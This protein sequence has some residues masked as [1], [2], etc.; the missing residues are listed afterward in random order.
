MQ[1]TFQDYAGQFDLCSGTLKTFDIAMDTMPDKRMRT[2]RVFL[3]DTYDG[4]R[5]FPVMYMH[6]GQNLFAGYDHRLMWYIEREMPKLPLEAQ[7]IVVGIDTA[8]TRREEL[9]PTWPLTPEWLERDPESRALGQNYIS[10]ICD[11]VKPII[12][13]NF[14]TKPEKEFTAIGGASMGGVISFYGHITRPEIF[15]RSLCFS[16]ALICHPADFYTSYFETYDFSQIRDDRIYFYNG[17]T[18]IEP[19]FLQPMLDMWKL[20]TEKGMDY[21]HVCAIVDTREPH[22]ETAWQKWYGDALK[23]LFCKDNSVIENSINKQR[24]ELYDRRNAALK[25]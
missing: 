15:G 7:C 4:E 1:V 19:R 23:Y 10:F 16:P 8:K 12:D 3:P 2:V 14:L 5:R 13:K 24:K 21:Q 6:D 25:I 18:T 9:T 22:F 11:T 20:L 17:G